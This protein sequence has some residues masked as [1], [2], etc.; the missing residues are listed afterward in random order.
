MVGVLASR[1]LMLGTEVSEMGDVCMYRFVDECRL[2]PPV[3]GKYPTVP[4]DCWCSHAEVKRA[5]GGTVRVP[6]KEG[7]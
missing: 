1:Q 3:N 6:R 5:G 7:E 4:D 2:N